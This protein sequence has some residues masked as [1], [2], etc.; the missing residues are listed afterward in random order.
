MVRGPGIGEPPGELRRDPFR[1]GAALV[2]VVLVNARENQCGMRDAVAVR[3][4][5]HVT[6]SQRTSSLYQI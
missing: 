3:Q 5:G 4:R 1:S 6:P 2:G